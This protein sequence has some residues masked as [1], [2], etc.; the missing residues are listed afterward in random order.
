MEWQRI[1]PGCPWLEP[2][3]P[4]LSPVV[5]SLLSVRAFVAY[6]CLHEEFQVNLRIL[7]ITV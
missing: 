6:L 5:T 4:W 3:C 7:A 2:G 1:L